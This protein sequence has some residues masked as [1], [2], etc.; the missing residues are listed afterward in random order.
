M[1]VGLRGSRLSRMQG[2]PREMGTDYGQGHNQELAYPYEQA[3]GAVIPGLSLILSR[4]RAQ[5]WT[6]LLP[7]I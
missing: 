2:H 7:V 1:R 3:H 4:K 5:H 6:H